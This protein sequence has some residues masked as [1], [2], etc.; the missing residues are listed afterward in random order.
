MPF[1]GG[2]MGGAGGMGGTGGGWGLGDLFGFHREGCPVPRP[3]L[4]WRH[5]EARDSWCAR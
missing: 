2:G 1:E 4:A 5:A 3:K